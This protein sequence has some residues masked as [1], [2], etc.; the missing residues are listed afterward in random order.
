MTYFESV[1][2]GQTFDLSKEIP[3]L[4]KQKK[5]TI[6]VVVDRLVIADDHVL[7][8]DFKTGRQVPEGPEGV[9]LRH[10]RQMAAY[11]AGLRRIH[12]GLP[13]RMALLY[14]ERPVLI[15][16]PDALLDRAYEQLVVSRT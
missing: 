6:E 3:A 14:T 12:P 10:L 9:D 13:V 15:G 4:D 2:D 7:A 16:I 1:I 11:R 8:V 5:H